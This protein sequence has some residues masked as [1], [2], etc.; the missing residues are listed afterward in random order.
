M[1]T[2]ETTRRGRW[3]WETFEPQDRHTGA[4]LAILRKGV[5]RDVGDIWQMARHYRSV[6]KTGD[7]SYRLA[8]EHAT[9]ALFAIHQQ[10]QPI[11][12]HR[13]DI[14]LGGAARRLH[15]PGKSKSDAEAGPAAI[16][17][18]QGKFSQEAVDSRV[19]QIATST[20]V[21]ELVAHLRGLVTMLRT[22]RQPLNYTRLHRDIERWHYPEAR[23]RIRARWGNHYFQWHSTGTPDS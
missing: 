17:G 7:A 16:G 23:T 18:D 20:S 8:A 2:D 5:G 4:E 22:I 3:Y 1:S 11:S 9:L 6:T 19:N 14:E 15:T 13:T 10:S 21:S 12:M